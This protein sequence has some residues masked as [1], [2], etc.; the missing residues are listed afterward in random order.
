[1]HAIA[2]LTLIALAGAACGACSGQPGASA[3]A[4][5]APTA[6]ATAAPAPA[7]ASAIPMQAPAAGA[8]AGAPQPSALLTRAPSLQVILERPSFA[9]A[10]AGMDGASALPAWVKTADQSQPSSRVQ[11]DGQALWLSHVCAASGCDGGELWL[12]TDPAGQKMQGLLV[13]ADGTPGAT[14]RQLTWLGKP[15]AAAQAVLKD[16]ASQG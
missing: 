14:V 1:M 8:S 9:R 2:K 6:A 5:S 10:F 15:D 3:P 11:V 16:H 7:P 13:T 12:L 4:D